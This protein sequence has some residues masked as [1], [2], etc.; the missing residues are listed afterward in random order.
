MVTASTAA[1]C[2]RNA[3]RA[4]TTSC[5]TTTPRKDGT[6]LNTL[7]VWRCYHAIRSSDVD[8]HRGGQI[9]LLGTSTA[10]PLS[11]AE[12]RVADPGLCAVYGAVFRA[13]RVFGHGSRVRS[14]GMAEFERSGLRIGQLLGVY[15]ELPLNAVEFLRLRSN[16]RT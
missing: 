12:H 6:G 7:K 15:A 5:P 4:P 3:L 2:G 13:A 9:T 11:G 1:P 14:A 10:P 8:H 16:V